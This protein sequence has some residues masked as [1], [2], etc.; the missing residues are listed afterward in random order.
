MGGIQWQSVERRCLLLIAPPDGADKVDG[1]ALFNV[2]PVV[3]SVHIVSAQL[4]STKMQQESFDQ[5]ARWDGTTWKKE[6]G[7]RLVR[8]ACD[9]EGDLCW[10]Q[11]RRPWCREDMCTEVGA[12]DAAAAQL[13]G[14]LRLY[15][16]ERL[17]V[18]KVAVRAAHSPLHDATTLH[19]VAEARGG[20]VVK[21]K[22]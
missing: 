20:L 6:W 10:G 17:E 13:A 21:D 19:Q 16:V 14:T 3:G 18:I 5:W 2:A 15:K 9:L 22:R 1:A 4:C 7:L 12:C 11:R 8:L